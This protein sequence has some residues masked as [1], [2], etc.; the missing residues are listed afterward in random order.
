MT[1]EQH[2]WVEIVMQRHYHQASGMLRNSPPLCF[3]G[4]N[5]RNFGQHG[6]GGSIGLGDPDAR[7]SFSYGTNKMHARKDNGPRAGLLIQSLYQSLGIPCETPA[8]E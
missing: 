4:P 8:Y 7:L 2:H 1:A 6:L 3:Q 5:P